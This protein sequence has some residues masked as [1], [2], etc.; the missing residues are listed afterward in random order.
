MGRQRTS[1][2]KQALHE[3]SC[4]DSRASWA[5][6]RVINR[7]ESIDSRSAQSDELIGDI[8]TMVDEGTQGAS[9]RNNNLAVSREAGRRV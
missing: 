9:I 7:I 2:A 1:S 8:L 5:R 3:L 6:V 4:N